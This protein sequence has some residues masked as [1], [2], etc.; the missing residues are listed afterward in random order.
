VGDG[1]PLFELR[2]TDRLRLIYDAGLPARE[3]AV[4]L[5][6]N[7][8]YSVEAGVCWPSHAQLAA[9]AGVSVPTVKRAL[10]VLRGSDTEPKIVTTEPTKTAMG[11]QSVLRYRIDFECLHQKVFDLAARSHRA[12]GEVTVTPPLGHGELAARSQR[13]STKEPPTRTSQGN[14]GSNQESLGGVRGGIGGRGSGIGDR[15]GR[16]PV[17]EADVAAVL[18]PVYRKLRLAPGD[19]DCVLR[20]L[21]AMAVAGRAPP[22]WIHGAAQATLDKLGP[23]HPR[24]MGYLLRL[25][26]SSVEAAGLD[27]EALLRQTK[28]PPPCCLA[29]DPPAAEVARV[30]EATARR[31][32]GAR[33]PVARSL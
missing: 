16:S 21:G 15:E 5:A 6:L 13:A 8:F 7:E 3:R 20:Q 11:F 25:V 14:Q 9:K 24:R 2:L 33:S 28:P 31:A 12:T 4:L 26:R 1:L 22:A 17:R 10:K 27:W 23:A 19:D 29:R 30:A 18:G 32:A